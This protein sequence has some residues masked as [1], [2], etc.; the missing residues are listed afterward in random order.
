VASLRPYQ[1]EGAAFLAARK[2]AL[3]TDVMRLGK[4]AQAITAARSLNLPSITVIGPASVR[5]VWPSEVSTW[6]PGLQLWVESYD[7]VARRP[8][9][10]PESRVVIFDEFHRMKNPK[11]KR[12]ALLLHPKV[13]AAEYVWG[14]S[15][16]PQPNGPHELFTVCSA[17]WPAEVRAL[18]VRREVDWW[19]LFTLWRESDYGR[20]YLV[21]KNPELLRAFLQGKMLGR[22]WPEVF[23]QL[24]PFSWE[25]L[26]LQV[27]VSWSAEAREQMEQA[28]LLL[29]LGELPRP[30]NTSALRRQI[31][32][33]KAALSAQLIAD[34]LDDGEP[35]VVVVYHHHDTGDLLEHALR[36]YGTVRVDG[37]TSR[38]AREQH[39]QAFQSGTVR[40]FLGQLDAIREGINLSTANV[41]H[42]VEP[43]W[44]P[45]YNEQVG[46]RIAMPD[47]QVACSVITHV[48]AG[49][50][51]E[52]VMRVLERKGAR[53]A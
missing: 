31:G 20:Q 51:D 44:T 39:R 16:T 48:L 17:F 23:S 30:T 47:K 21:P 50:I 33:E 9:R 42:L 37:D 1:Q 53:A 46:M 36:G 35:Q 18:G 5:D 15:G 13:R 34:S 11:A 6:A 7:T 26:R 12:A 52:A 27:P 49:T 41:L 45:G 10:I 22:R 2:R 43:S 4:T 8:E 32:R 29:Q 24:A 3:L 25:T 28:E 14:L 38:E 40:V 19:N